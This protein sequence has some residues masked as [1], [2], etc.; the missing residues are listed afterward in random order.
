MSDSQNISNSVPLSRDNLT[1]FYREKS[2]GDQKRLSKVKML[3]ET[4]YC[5]SIFKISHAEWKQ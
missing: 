3:K 2:V 5:H 4:N 1:C